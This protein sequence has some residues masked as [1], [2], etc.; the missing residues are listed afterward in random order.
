MSSSDHLS[1]TRFGAESDRN[2]PPSEAVVEAVAAVAGRPPT[3]TDAARAPLEPLFDTIDPDALDRL[4]DAAGAG[5][6]PCDSVSFVY[7]GYEVTVTR[8]GRVAVSA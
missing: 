6:R 8:D 2:R 7:S 4:F 5:G 3:D 1:T